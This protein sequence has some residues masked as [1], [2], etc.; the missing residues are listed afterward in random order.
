MIFTDSTYKPY[1]RPYDE[2][3]YIHRESN[4]PPSITKLLPI[5]IETSLSKTYL[6]EKVFN[7]SNSMYQEVLDKSGY[8]H[9]LK[10]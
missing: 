3:C 9:K 6:K 4:H 1:Q 10:R 7:E 8:N 5:F 2:I